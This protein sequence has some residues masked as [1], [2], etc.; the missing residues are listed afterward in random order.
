MKKVFFMS[1]AAAL[2]TAC[3]NDEVMPV[4]ND[5]NAIRFGV[6]AENSSRAADVYCPT[7]IF[8][9]FNVFATYGDKMYIDNDLIEKENG[10]W[11]NKTGLRY[12][13]NTGNVTFYGYVNGTL[14]ITNLAAPKFTN[15]APDAD[16][17]KQVDLLYAR[18]TKSKPENSTDKVELNF[19]HALS[20]IVFNARN[21]NSN[22][23]VEIDS[24]S[25]VNVAGSGTYT[26]PTED[27]NN[28]LDHNYGE[29]T[30]PENG[31]GKWTFAENIT[32]D[33]KYSVAVGKNAPVAVVGDKKAVNLTDWSN[34]TAEG[35]ITAP[36]AAT[37]EQAML[38]IPQS[39]TAFDTK[40]N[41][42]SQNGSY[43]LVRCKIWNVAGATVVK[44]GVNA[45][46]VLWE[47]EGQ[48]ANVMIPADFN[49][50]EGKKYIY[51]FVFGNG[52]GGYNPD[53]TDPTPDPVLVPITFDVTV[54]EF[55]EVNGGVVETFTPAAE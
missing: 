15:F 40:Q 11:V 21:D 45:D 48:P 28:N 35:A 39:T 13:P 46:I 36:E 47:K 32:L 26:L 54:D 22:L 49:W 38:L 52:N 10:Q 34:H 1:M 3:S 12:W 51:T 18:T 17:A 37:V 23:Y 42:T 14:D 24:V 53:P 30:Y 20:Q 16:V 43:F 27:T 5:A 25:I 9:Q 50:E 44:E 2:L 29:A 33:A 19:R 4:N 41:I 31:H 6:T 55:F 8:N 7:N